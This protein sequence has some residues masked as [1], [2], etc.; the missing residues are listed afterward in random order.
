MDGRVFDR[1]TRTLGTTG[2]RRAALAALIAANALFPWGDA[3]GKKHKPDRHDPAKKGKAKNK[4]KARAQVENC[5]RAGNC[6]PKKKGNVSQC[7]LSH[8]TVCSG[9]DCSKS[10]FSRANLRGSNLTNATLTGSNLTNA[11]LVDADFT[12]ANLS[13]V[14]AAGAVMCRTK[15]P[16]GAPNNSGCGL[17]SEC[18]P[19]CDEAHACA[20]GQRCCAGR[21]VSAQCCGAGDCPDDQTCK[22]RD[23]IGG[24]CVY[25]NQTPDGNAGTGCANPQQ[26]CNGVCCPSGQTCCNGTCCASGKC[27]GNTC[28]A[29]DCCGNSCCAPG[30]R[31][32]GGTCIPEESC[33]INNSPT[34]CPAGQRC[35]EPTGTCSTCCDPGNRCTS[36]FHCRALLSSTCG[37]G[38]AVCRNGRCC[39]L[40]DAP[41]A[42]DEYNYACCSG[43]CTAPILSGNFTC[44]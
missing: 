7:D 34:N 40:E 27:C 22:T 10:N 8:T 17:G 9:E 43:S 3:A 44:D 6:I 31:C 35:C 15:M 26:C 2:T 11:C 38:G 36:D 33:C 19:V 18:C 16:N 23:C 24:Q 32:C 30:Q 25:A 14:N 39:L 28:C 13:G 21:C 29:G 37:G 5:W 41:C 1:L 20:N 42:S 4:K 12:G